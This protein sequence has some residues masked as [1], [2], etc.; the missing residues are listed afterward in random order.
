MK[1]STLLPKFG[2]GTPKRLRGIGIAALLLV[3]AATP[4]FAQTELFSPVQPAESATAKASHDLV[5]KGGRV[6]DPASGRD[7]VLNIGISGGRIVTLSADELAGDNIINAEG[8]IIAPGFIDL[9]THSPF[10]FGELFQVKDGVTTSLDLEAGAWPVAQYGEFIRNKAHANYGSSVGHFAVR[11][12]VIEGKDQPYVVTKA[13]Q[14]VPGAA[15]SQVATPAQIE[16]MRRL[17]QQGLDNGGLGIGFLLDYMSPAVSDAE[18]KMIFEVAKAN[19]TVVWIHIRR[20]VN[21]DIQPLMDILPLAQKMGVKLHISHI[22]A[23]AMGAIGPWLKAID[24]ANAKGA[25]V[26]AE[27][28]PYTAGS[29]SIM[30]DVFNRDWQTIFGITYGDVQWATTGERFTKDS[31]DAARR[32]H[33]DSSVIHHYMKEEWLVEGMRWPKMMVATD[34]IPAISFEVKGPPNGAGSFTRLLA[35]Y[36][37]DDKVLELM[38]AL[39]RGSTYPADRLAEFAPLFKRKGRIEVGADADLLI[40]KLENL[41]DNATYT[42]PY[43]E[44]SGWDWVLVGGEVV[45]K[46]GDAT[47]ATPGQHV[48]NLPS[49]E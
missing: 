24:A 19:D 23:N 7:E 26:S 2:N 11:I 43:R 4:V 9:H 31:W 25:D 13:G 42:D 16:E 49:G 3:T 17:L 37:R 5:I 47:G 15:F 35:K 14:M 45:V 1:T 46:G 33:P 8:R 21:G 48:L 38:D 12:K 28:F 20:G 10:P 39:R 27:V 29:T 40:F 32:D 44:A 36:V 22:N 30:S 41:R 18:L 6:L 34:A